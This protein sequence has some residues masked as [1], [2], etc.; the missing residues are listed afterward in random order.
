MFNAFTLPVYKWNAAHAVTASAFPKEPLRT[1]DLRL[2]CRANSLS[3]QLFGKKLLPNYDGPS[4][5]TG[6]SFGVD[7]LYQQSNKQ[8]LS[9]SCDLDKEINEGFKDFSKD[10][11]I[12][13]QTPFPPL[14]VM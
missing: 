7:Y 10:P 13:S 11:P 5:Y 6:E 2:Q 9:S 12:S 4:Q 3:Q 1:F 14:Q 8:L